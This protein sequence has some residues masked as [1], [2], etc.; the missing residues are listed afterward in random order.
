MNRGIKYKSSL[1]FCFILFSIILTLQILFR[2][3]STSDTLTS[4]TTIHT[5]KASIPEL[6]RNKKMTVTFTSEENMLGIIGIPIATYNRENTDQILFRIKEASATQWYYQNI[7]NTKSFADGAYY[8]FGFPK[9]NN[10]KGKEYTIEIV[11]QNGSKGNAIGILKNNKFY[12]KYVYTKDNFKKDILPF[13]LKK[14]KY[15]A[16]MFFPIDYVILF[17]PFLSLIFLLVINKQV[18]Q[19]LNSFLYFPG[20]IRHLYNQFVGA[21]KSQL[22]ELCFVSLFF[23]LF[24]DLALL[25]PYTQKQNIPL[26]SVVFIVLLN[27]L[28]V[29]LFLRAYSL[30]DKIILSKVPI[31]LVIAICTFC[32]VRLF[33]IT[34]L[35]RW[36]SANNFISIIQGVRGFDFTFNRFLTDY[37]WW[38]HSSH[39]ISMFVSFFQFFGP[40]NIILLHLAFLTLTVLGIISLYVIFSYFIGGNKINKTLCM[41]LI[42]FNPLFFSS[43]LLVSPDFAVLIFFTCFLACFIRKKYILAVFF[44]LLAVF[45]KEI[46]IMIYFSFIFIYGILNIR[47]N[48]RAFKRTQ[49]FLTH[50]II[51]FLTPIFVFFLYILV[52]NGRV[53]GGSALDIPS[54][55][56]YN[57]DVFMQRILQMFILNF[58]WITSTCLIVWLLFV[59]KVIKYDRK[60]TILYS[61]IVTDLV[62]VLFNLFYNTVTHPRYVVLQVFFTILFFSIISASIISNTLYRKIFLSIILTLNIIQCF[63]TIDPISKLVFKTYMFGNHEILKISDDFSSR[64]DSM[65]YNTQYIY[66][67]R[68]FNKMNQ[69]IGIMPTD[70]LV[71]STLRDVP[72]WDEWLTYYERAYI[73]NITRK[74]TYNDKDSFKPRLYYENNLPNSFLDNNG[75]L[76][77]VLLPWL[78]NRSNTKHT[79]ILTQYPLNKEVK[80]EI[81]GYFLKVYLLNIL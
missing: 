33:F 16:K 74:L 30:K 77:Y 17:F 47:D 53:W 27:L 81:D 44:A 40:G 35:P 60:S 3:R 38:G 71:F 36:D 63:L 48:V 34:D 59:N 43:S 7:Y 79:S 72:N 32:V 56:R 9:I 37:G 26:L 70:T 31:E 5:V 62:F 54:A 57:N 11:S 67:N 58:G 51:L 69:K 66:I 41:L 4:L 64:C 50:K 8:P 65:V 73:D 19:L 24:A 49:L 28:T 39:G 55:F 6:L 52:N 22:I 2:V 20:H 75:R 78:S 42:I 15:L 25:S 1:L 10:S 45:S 80:V 76:F 14:S 68:L 29:T 46:G 21:K 23:T 12:T 61:L 13:L 18:V